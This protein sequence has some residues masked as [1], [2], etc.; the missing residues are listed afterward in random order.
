GHATVSKV[1]RRAERAQAAA[2]RSRC[3]VRQ[4]A[5]YPFQQE[6]GGEFGGVQDGRVLHCGVPVCRAV[7]SCSRS[8]NQAQNAGSGSAASGSSKSG[9]RSRPWSL[10]RSLPVTR[11]ASACAP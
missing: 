2:D 9:A 3:P 11:T 7:I 8:S 5:Q 6:V 10:T 1:E 4:R